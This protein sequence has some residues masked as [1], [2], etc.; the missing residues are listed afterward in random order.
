[1]TKQ[2][3]SAGHRLHLKNDFEQIIHGGKRIQGFGLIL[4][5]KPASNP[6]HKPRLGI[7]VSRK[8][9]N[10]VVRNRIKRL[11]REAFRLYRED[12]QSGVDYVFSP[13]CSEQ[14]ATFSQMQQALQALCQRAGLWQTQGASSQTHL[15]GESN[16]TGK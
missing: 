1:M 14:L 15:K 9:A 10:A 5:Y 7:V 4:W 16:D 11:L 2:G 13:R 6:T 12:L 3:F 8:L